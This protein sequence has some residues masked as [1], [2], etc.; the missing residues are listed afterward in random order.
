MDRSVRFAAWTGLFAAG[1]L[2]AVAPQL[3]AV[4][5]GPSFKGAS[6]SFVILVWMLPVAMLS[7]HH[8]YILIAYSCQ[9]RLLYCT[10]LSAAAAVVLSFALVPLYKGPGAAWAVL[11]A[12]IIN[13]ALVYVSVRQLVVEVPIHRQITMPLS[14]LALAIVFYLAFAKWNV[15]IAS[16]GGV[17][18][19]FVGLA[20]SDGR[21]LAGFLQTIF[22]KSGTMTEAKI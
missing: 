8:R 14:A 17:L 4:I 20:C 19:Y 9:K 10:S 13:F 7:G 11:I 5:Y 18:C 12:N 6:H 15:W 3:L 21:Q 1:L 22:R 2:T 16:V